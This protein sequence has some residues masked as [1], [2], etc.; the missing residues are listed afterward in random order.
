[1][2]DLAENCGSYSG[3]DERA[4]LPLV[5][6]LSR[7][8]AEC[9]ASRVF[10]FTS[11]PFYC[12]I[13]QEPNNKYGRTALSIVATAQDQRVCCWGDSGWTLFFFLIQRVGVGLHGA[14]LIICAE[15]AVV[16]SIWGPTAE[17]CLDRGFL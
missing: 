13:G 12:S 5:W 11:R 8:P 15:L 7:E 9:G 16:Y 10:K 6:L 1:M 14:L 17:Q 4:V 3:N 2:Y